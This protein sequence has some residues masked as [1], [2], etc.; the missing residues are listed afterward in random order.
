M[1]LAR[2]QIARIHSS[3]IIRKRQRLT[4]EPDAGQM[5]MVAPS[6]R[7]KPRLFRQ[8]LLLG[9]VVIG[10]I[11]LGACVVYLIAEALSLVVQQL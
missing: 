10:A 7:E 5:Q 3:S 4:D 8:T 9:A 6:Q 1:G 2:C 11:F